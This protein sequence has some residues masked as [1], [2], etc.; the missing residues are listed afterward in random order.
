MARSLTETAHRDGKHL[1]HSAGPKNPMSHRSN[2]HRS[3]K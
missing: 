3:I 2:K 1:R